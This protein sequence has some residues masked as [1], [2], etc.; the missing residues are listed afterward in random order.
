MSQDE[1]KSDILSPPNTFFGILYRLGPGLIIAGSIVG[2][3]ELI[4]TTST[5]AKAEFWLLWLIIV[6][7]VI[8]V[9]V[10][11]ELGRYSIVSGKTTMAALNELPGPRFGKL[12]NW[13]IWYWFLMFLASIAQLGG[14]VGSV[15]QAMA[16][17]VPSTKYAKDFNAWADA[18][19]RTIITLTETNRSLAKSQ[20]EPKSDGE[21]ELPGSSVAIGNMLKVLDDEVQKRATLGGDKIPA[22]Q[23]DLLTRL[24]QQLRKL[25]ADQELLRDGRF[26]KIL[27]ELDGGLTTSPEG[28]GGADTL[29]ALWGKAQAGTFA[30]D[31]VAF[32]KLAEPAPP[33]DDKLWAGLITF[34][35]M[36]LLVVGRFTLIELV[37]TALVAIFTFVTVANVILLQFNESWAISWHDLQH[38]FSFRLPPGEGAAG[39][40]ALSIA[41]KTFGIIGVGA[42]ELLAYPYWCMEKGYAKFTGPRDKTEEWAS[43]AK[44]WMRVMRWDSFCSMV[45]Y[46]AATVAFYLLGAA[47]LGRSGLFPEDKDLIRYLSVMYQP[48]FGEFAQILFFFGAFAVLYSTFFIANAGHARV[49]ADAFGVMGLVS[50]SEESKR[51][52]VRFFSGLFPVICLVIFLAFP[53]PT[54]LVLLSG[55]M[56]AVMLPMLAGAALFFRY[57]RIDERIRPTRLWDIFLWVSS[58]GMLLTGCILVW[59]EVSKFLPK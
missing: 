40:N 54:A 21:G 8:K 6:G 46:T 50:N 1:A 59:L 5:G 42:A 47:V 36:I 2:S 31:Y 22:D 44:G 24:S 10:Q 7:C 16:I 55:M 35:T 11:V 20:A 52:R 45:V 15:G 33:I 51:A 29:A 25:E 30:A 3:G 57:Y 58:F 26:L 38:G 4:A 14:I 18:K 37:S 23:K 48:V 34:V 41:L 49:V 19:T 17:S 27:K 32:R 13:I 28:N 53:K 43:R 39:S 56:Q 12:G 9:F